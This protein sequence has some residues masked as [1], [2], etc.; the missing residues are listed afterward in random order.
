MAV[1]GQA[2]LAKVGVAVVFGEVAEV[3]VPG[4]SWA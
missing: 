4:A 2:D 3:E 1:L